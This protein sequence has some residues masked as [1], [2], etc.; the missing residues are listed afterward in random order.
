MH[1][2]ARVVDSFAA[3]AQRQLIVELLQKTEQ[4]HSSKI[5]FGLLQR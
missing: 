5:Y 3:E 4:G 1:H 2:Q